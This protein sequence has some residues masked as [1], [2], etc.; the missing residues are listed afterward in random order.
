M[1]KTN[2]FIYTIIFFIIFV[3]EFGLN[4]YLSFNLELSQYLFYQNIINILPLFTV[5]MGFGTPFAVIYMT[6]LSKSNENKYL[7]ESNLFTFYFSLILL[8]IFLI[9]F[10]FDYI[11]LYILVALILGFFNAIKQNSVNFYLAKKELSKS[12]FIRLNQ[13]LIYLIIIVISIYLLTINNNGILSTILIIGE[14]V[15]FIILVYKYKIF[16]FKKFKKIKSILIISKYAFLAN[17]FGMISLATPIVLLNYFDY[18]TIDIISFSIAYTLLRYSG[19]LLGP[20]MQLITPYFTPIKN[21]LKKVKQ[22]YIKY[23]FIIFL[24]GITVSIVMYY[25]SE[26]IINIFFSEVYNQ[27]IELFKILVIVIPI[28]ILSSFTLTLISSIIG[29]NYTSNISIFGAFIMFILVIVALI[30][31]DIFFLVYTVIAHSLYILLSGSYI[32]NK[33]LN[34]KYVVQKK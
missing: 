27:A 34:K 14:I 15:G 16:I 8:F 32:L 33:K 18:P 21:D 11:H 6:S 19:I 20:F 31:F 3:I 23:S 10:S 24:L 2:I 9:L 26:Y 30:E 7:L 13:K 29:V 5:L 17:L 28:M 22:L 12:S 1:N 25:L 4:S